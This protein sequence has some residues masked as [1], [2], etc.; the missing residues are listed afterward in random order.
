MPPKI[1]EEARM[2]R[3]RAIAEFRT[4]FRLLPN[5]PQTHAFWTD[6]WRLMAG[7]TPVGTYFACESE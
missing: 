7:L 3:T 6:A 4:G 5:A 1:V 2:A